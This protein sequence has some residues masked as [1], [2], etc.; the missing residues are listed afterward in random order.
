M[1]VYT[2]KFIQD[3]LEPIIAH[4]C[5]AQGV[6]GAGVAEAIKHVWPEAYEVYKNTYNERGLNLGEVLYVNSRGR[7]IANCITQR[8]YGRAA[9][10][11]VDYNA[12]SMC[13]DNLNSYMLEN[14]LWSISMPK[15]GAGLGGGDWTRIE[16]LIK[17]YFENKTEVVI[18]DP[19]F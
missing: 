14:D 18:Y 2:E 19:R 12:M 13:F 7:I 6:M 8:F 17:Q 4:G 15:I 16:S 11:Y 1:I 10:R 3:S 9:K 5:N